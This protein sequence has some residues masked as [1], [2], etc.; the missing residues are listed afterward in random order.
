MVLRRFGRRRRRQPRFTYSAWDGTQADYELT[1]DD[2]FR[3]MTDDLAYHG[4]PN[5]ALR[6]MLQ[7]GFDLDGERMQGLRE[8]LERL[9]EQRQEM[10]ESGDL[11]GAFSDIAEKLRDIVDTE[12][13]NLDAQ[14]EYS[15]AGGDPDQA[16]RDAASATE[17]HM[18]LDMLP[19]DLPG[20]IR[21]LEDYDFTS[22]E[23]QQRFDELLDELRNQ[24]MQQAVDGMSD[25]MQNMSAEDMQRVKDMLSDLNQ[26]LEDR[27]NGIEPDFDAFMDQHGDFF[28]ENPETLDELLEAMAARMAAAQAMLNSM[29]PEQRAQLQELSDQLL[30]DMDLQW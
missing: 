3:Q 22:K 7:N 19:P 17:R 29:T 12:R 24:L 25:A 18:R 16:A 2:L 23:A 9:R 13:Q 4:D 1:A 21:S 20:Q 27:A 15:S 10:L 6:N 26:M 30:G 5:A 8:M 14:A 11:G 28:P